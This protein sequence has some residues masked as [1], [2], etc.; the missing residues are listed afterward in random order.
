[1]SNK[2]VKWTQWSKIG[3]TDYGEMP[4]KDVGLHIQKFERLAKAMLKDTGADHILYS[5]A[6]YDEQGDI[7]KVSFYQLALTDEEYNQKTA[8]IENAK[9]YALHSK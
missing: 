2:Y 8:A 7:S 3:M 9:V 1:M 6:F 4:V 5:I